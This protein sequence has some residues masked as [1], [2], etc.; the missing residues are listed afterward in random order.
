MNG[1]KLIINSADSLSNALGK[2]SAAY[3]EKKYIRVTLNFGKDRSLAQNN[4]I[5]KWFGEISEQR[6]EHTPLE[7]K[8]ICKRMF[9]MPILRADSSEFNELLV[10]LGHLDEDKKMQLIEMLPVTSICTTKQ[11][12]RGM[13]DMYLFYTGE[14]VALT[15]PDEEGL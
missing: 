6:G 5:H 8:T 10:S 15:Q 14:G 7:V 1:M 12:T 4:L 13:D 11:M 3:R 2:I 9:F